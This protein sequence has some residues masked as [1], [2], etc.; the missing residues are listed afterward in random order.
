MPSEK[1][2]E[3]PQEED[4]TVPQVKDMK[5]RVRVVGWP[6]I[7]EGGGSYVLKG[8]LATRLKNGGK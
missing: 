7:G 4:V 5:A 6:L 8:K 2:S 1:R 3:K